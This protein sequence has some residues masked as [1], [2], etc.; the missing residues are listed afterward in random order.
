MRKWWLAS[1]LVGPA[2]LAIYA[3]LLSAIPL[4]DPFG[5]TWQV[6]RWA[7]V[8]H[9]TAAVV[10][11]PALIIPFWASHRYLITLSRRA[12]LVW[13]GR[14]LEGLL[15]L[16][17]LTGAWLL[18]I[19][20]NGT[21]PV[22]A[23]HWTHLAVALPLVVLTV[24]HAW[25]TSVIR[26]GLA[27]IMLVGVL[28]GL[29]TPA[30]GASSVESRSLLLEDG[31]RTL[32][33]AN[34][35]AGSV[36]R[37][38]RASGD[39]LGE[40][41]LGGDIR[42]LAVDAADGLVA[43]TDFTG[44][45]VLF[46][47]AVEP[48]TQQDR[49]RCRP[50]VRRRLGCPQPRSS[51]SPPRRRTASVA[52]AA[53]GSVKLDLAVAE[54]PRGL[55]LLP[56]GRLL[57]SHAF[58]GAVSIYDTTSLPPK[59]TKLIT[60][61][62]SQN[63][64][65]TVSQGLPRVLDRVA[66]S[67]DGKQA[68]LPHELWNF[69]HPF[70][71]Q[72][73]VF[74]AISVI[75]LE[76]GN[77]HEAVPRRMQLFKQIN[78]IENGSETR[79]VSNPADVAFNGDGSK[80]YAT[81]AGSE[82][83]VVFDLSRAL[84]IDSKSPKA[85]TTDGAHAV[86]IF[87]HLPGENPRGLVVD[88]DDIFVQNAM[89]LDLSKLSAGGAGSFARVKV[90]APSFAK[91]VAQDPLSPATRRGERIFNLANTSVFP[92][93]PLTGNNWMSCQSCHVDGF[94]FSNRALFRDTPVDKFHSSFTGHGTIANFVAGDFVGDYIR[95]IRD[96]QGGMGADTRFPT[97]ETDPAKPS[98]AVA[99][100]MQDLHAYVTAPGNLPLLATWLRGEGSGGKV[101]A[102]DWT[103]SAICADCHARI[104]KDW[105]NSTHRMMAQSDPYYVVLEDLAAKTEG[106]GF[107]AWC[108]GCH[109]PQA[110]LSGAT[111]T[112]APANMF[113]RDGAKPR[114][115][116]AELRPHHRRGYRLP[117][118][119]PRRQAGRCR[120][121][122]R[123]QRLAQRRARRSPALSRRDLRHRRAPC[124]RR[125][126]HPREARCP[127]RLAA[128]PRGRR[129]EA[130]RPRQAVRGVLEQPEAGPLRLEI[131]A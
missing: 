33:S 78:I 126:A 65:E 70:Q 108:M 53:D 97:P 4:F 57:V 79:I 10:L 90:V 118:L 87:R 111:K 122:R 128:G 18:F 75:S 56:D 45:N 20:W 106:E 62:S 26:R 116:P 129:P 89:G 31:G 3:L 27:A 102:T 93:A 72:S 59:L 60:L 71:F 39:R 43:A 103:N 76:P 120:R 92:D 22:P 124:L 95:M 85:A 14:V 15:T 36:A 112:D 29:A 28:F 64:D 35:D 51:G 8:V 119:P 12:F 63:P 23:A 94:N 82:D 55:A 66:V 40:V 96:T 131:A 37:V 99:A 21:S 69:D 84:P 1:R 73:T 32:L 107:R 121:A 113:D 25:R 88:G 46:L 2:E 61:A 115:R 49:R 130:L 42:S 24:V 104:F 109:A 86:E 41:F 91:L 9:V 44:N 19:G 114:R 54:S 100:M 58:I 11:V 127:R 50:S 16:A 105:S 52:I 123:R 47:A 77:E 34:F 30:T 38:D 74:P 110:L 48:V 125:P 98:A 13:T 17:F 6:Q 80:A 7:L 68:W 117:V 83:L 5:F 101:A 67:P 81:M